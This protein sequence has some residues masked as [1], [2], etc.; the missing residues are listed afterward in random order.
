MAS[1]PVATDDPYG[2]DN[3]GVHGDS[4]SSA[5]V[6]PHHSLS[7]SSSSSA[8]Q[9]DLDDACCCPTGWVHVERDIDFADPKV[10]G[11]SLT[12]SAR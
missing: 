4:V 2:D 9:T 1:D 8:L 10:T 3:S 6:P 7:A 12:F 11:L 5:V